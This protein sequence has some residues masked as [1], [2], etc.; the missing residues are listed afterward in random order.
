MNEKGYQI[1]DVFKH[2]DLK[3][4]RNLLSLAIE[5]KCVVI[6][7]LIINFKTYKQYMKF[8]Q[9]FY[10]RIIEIIK[11]MLKYWDNCNIPE[12]INP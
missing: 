12:F 8:I 3:T 6:L 5:Q 4:K 1:K 9:K 7:V 11:I 10:I 2:N